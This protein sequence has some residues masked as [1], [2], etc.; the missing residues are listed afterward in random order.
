[1]N[2]GKISS[3][4]SLIFASVVQIW[5]ID[6]TH[7]S[8]CFTAHSDWPLWNKHTLFY[9]IHVSTCHVKADE[10]VTHLFIRMSHL[11]LQAKHI[12][13]SWDL[14]A[15]CVQHGDIWWAESALRRVFASNVTA[16]PHNWSPSLCQDVDFQTQT[17][18]LGLNDEASVMLHSVVRPVGRLTNLVMP[19]DEMLH[20]RSLNKKTKIFVF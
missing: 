12:Q 1:M 14:K 17:C 3:A 2:L 16:P 8:S 4:V 5:K 13:L 10:V 9:C 18:H 7:P 6:V 15:Q 11:I 20:I 19:V